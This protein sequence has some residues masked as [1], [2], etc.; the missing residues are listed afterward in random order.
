MVVR[1]PR[2]LAAVFTLWNQSRQRV[3]YLKDDSLLDREHC[4]VS[5]RISDEDLQIPVE[6]FATSQ[7]FLWTLQNDPV[8]PVTEP[9]KLQ[10]ISTYMIDFVVRLSESYGHVIEYRSS[11]D[12]K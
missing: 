2:A 3:G 7:D 9:E 10:I 12:N 11:N 4:S 8:A 5:Q 1:R 6:A